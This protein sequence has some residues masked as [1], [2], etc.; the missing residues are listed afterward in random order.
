MRNYSTE[1]TTPE[2]IKSESETN[3]TSNNF[4]KTR[5]IFKKSKTNL[6]LSKDSNIYTNLK[7]NINKRNYS[8]LNNKTYNQNFYSLKKKFFQ[9]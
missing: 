8:N 2:N 6:D 9:I 3:D 7:I 5:N 4:F 1:F